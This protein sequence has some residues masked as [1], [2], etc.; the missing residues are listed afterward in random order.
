MNEQPLRT[1]ADGRLHVL[2][3]WEAGFLQDTLDKALTQVQESAR[4]WFW[5][6]FWETILGR[7]D[8]PGD[9]EATSELFRLAGEAH[10]GRT[11]GHPSTAQ[12][13]QG[14]RVEFVIEL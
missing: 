4:P 5:R 2:R 8:R 9:S 6:E 13:R 3:D 7:S 10:L 14:A 12:Q 11:G 1:L